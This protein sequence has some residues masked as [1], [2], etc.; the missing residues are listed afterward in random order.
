MTVNF[1]LQ[2]YLD[3]IGHRGA[4]AADLSTLEA[5][6]RRH[7]DAIPFENLDPLLGRPVSLDLSALQAKLVG[8]RRGGY[9]FEHNTLLRG[10]LEA[11]GFSV[12]SLSARVRW[13]A[14]HRPLGARTHML[15]MVDLADGPWIA[16]VGFGHLLDAPLRLQPDIEQRSPTATYRLSGAGGYFELATLLPSGWQPIYLLSTEPQ[17]PADFEVANWWTSTSP[18]TWL[19]QSLLVQRLTAAAR[20]QLSNRHLTERRHDGTLQERTLASAQELG[21]VLDRVFGV[22]PPASAEAVFARLPP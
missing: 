18:Q 21:E 12:T 1:N 5:I 7:V 19:T 2:A 13:N 11:L 3:R 16:D 14:L 8:S 4:A 20:F 10:A 22:T 15:L 9:C 6:H 17:V